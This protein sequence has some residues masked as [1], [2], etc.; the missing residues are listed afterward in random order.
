MRP[1]RSVAI[2]NCHASLRAILPV[3][4]AYHVVASTDKA[5]VS[6]RYS[7]Y[8]HAIPPDQHVTVR[9]P[10]TVYPD[11][12]ARGAGRIAAQGAQQFFDFTANP[13]TLVHIE[14]KCACP[15]LAIRAVSVGD[16]SR[17][18]YW[19]LSANFKDDWKLPAGGKYTIQVRSNGFTGDYSFAASFAQPHH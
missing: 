2:G 13:G 14:G 1:A 4:G 11:N 10:L 15:N 3:T 19:D 9:L 12:P 6:S 8:V 5:S 16:D 18:G 17:F 7:F